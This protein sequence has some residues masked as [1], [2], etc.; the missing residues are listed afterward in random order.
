MAFEILAFFLQN[1]DFMI[2]IELILNDSI[3]NFPL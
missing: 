3:I 2:I 1:K